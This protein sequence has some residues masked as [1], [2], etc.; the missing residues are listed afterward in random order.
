MRYSHDYY[1]IRKIILLYNCTNL[2][3]A[4]LWK[5]REEHLNPLIYKFNLFNSKNPARYETLS[6]SLNPYQLQE[7]C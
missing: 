6:K 5:F 1:E 2:A 4:M 7:R 3:F